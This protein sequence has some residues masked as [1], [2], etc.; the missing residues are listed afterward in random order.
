VTASNR[1][2]GNGSSGSSASINSSESMQAVRA[3]SHPSANCA[4]FAS[5]PT[6]VPGATIAAS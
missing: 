3:A 6:V 5:T 2:S 1:A 4:P